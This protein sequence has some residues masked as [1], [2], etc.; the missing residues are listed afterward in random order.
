MV[1]EGCRVLACWG[2]EGLGKVFQEVYQAEINEWL[3]MNGAGAGD[4]MVLMKWCDQS[5][6]PLTVTYYL[7]S[8]DAKSHTER[9]DKLPCT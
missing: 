4:L 3:H 9:A 6:Y 1:M 5:R 2:N 7:I 8:R